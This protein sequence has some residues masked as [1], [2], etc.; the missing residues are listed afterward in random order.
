MPERIALL[1]QMCELFCM[2][3][4]RNNPALSLKVSLRGPLAL[5]S[6]EKVELM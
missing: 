2:L 1:L 3:D 4:L 6:D 5:N